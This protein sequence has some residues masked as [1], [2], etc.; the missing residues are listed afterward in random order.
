MTKNPAALAFI[1][2]FF[3]VSVE[4]MG[5]FDCVHCGGS[6]NFRRQMGSTLCPYCGGSSIAKDAFAARAAEI[7]ADPS[8]G[9]ELLPPANPETMLVDV[10]GG[11]W[12]DRLQAVASSQFRSPHQQILFWIQNSNRE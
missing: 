3:G 1:A 10:L 6:G 7:L 2:Q 9:A 12:H 5:Q 8:F 11:S 4:E